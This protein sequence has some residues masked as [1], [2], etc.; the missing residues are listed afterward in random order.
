MYWPVRVTPVRS[1]DVAVTVTAFGTVRPRKQLDITPQVSGVVLEVSP[2][3]ISGGFVAEGELLLRIDP[4]DYE[5]AVE[6]A[7]AEGARATYELTRASE[8]A[9]VARQ[10]WEM[11]RD[12]SPSAF[13]DQPPAA[14]L[15]R[16]SSG[17]SAVS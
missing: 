1:E 17:V 12:N 8:E 10:E 15:S 4:R 7:R 14:D 16:A 2:N 11:L 13:G 3:L 9:E 5:L 6:R